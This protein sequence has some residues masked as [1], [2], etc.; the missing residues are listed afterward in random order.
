MIAFEPAARPTAP[1]P[2]V[3]LDRDGVLIANRDGDYARTPEQVVPLPRA[4][5]ALR[6][7]HAAGLRTVVISNQAAVGK[8]L[9][10]AQ[11]ARRVHEEVLRRFGSAGAGPW[12]GYLCPHAP[13][14]RCPCRKPRPGLIEHAARRL[15]L[16]LTRSHLVGDALSDLTA[17]ESVGV[18]SY[19][20]L[21]GRGRAQASLPQAVGLSA[22][23]I[24]PDLLAA[25]DAILAGPG[26]T[27]PAHDGH[28]RPPTLTG[29]NPCAS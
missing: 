28:R 13:S 24:H 9:M 22:D 18:R 19:L 2:A 16:D 27:A 25:V 4:A 1:Q 21:T 17:G 20:V 29:S 23:R 3:F 15:N 14:E 5:A 11:A 7:L 8:G 12:A 26:R 10:T 6:R